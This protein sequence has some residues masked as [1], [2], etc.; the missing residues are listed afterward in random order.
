M[1]HSHVCG[2]L[3][4][5]VPAQA[6]SLARV[7]RLLRVFLAEHDVREDLQHGVVLVTHELA[8]NAIVHGSTDKDEVVA[9]T[10]RLGPQSLLIRVRDPARSEAIPA[11]LEPTDWR[12]SGR[13]MLMVG[14]LATWSEEL[15]DGRREVSATL[16]LVP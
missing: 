2:S 9:I 5:S 13:G 3:E 11:S 14:Q 8:A 15:I 12:E 16:P 4:I 1:E 7:R 6:A 10:L